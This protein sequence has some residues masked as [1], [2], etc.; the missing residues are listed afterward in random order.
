MINK[1]PA[2]YRLGLFLITSSIAIVDQF[3]ASLLGMFFYDDSLLWPVRFAL[4]LVVFALNAKGLFN[5]K[6]IDLQRIILVMAFFLTLCISFY[7]S[8]ANS[9]Q[10]IRYILSHIYYLFI[11][12]YAFWISNAENQAE[13][14]K[15]VLQIFVFF[16]MLSSLGYLLGEW[17][18][19][20]NPAGI[21][22]NII[23]FPAYAIISF[24]VLIFKRP[25]IFHLFFLFAFS[26][27][28]LAIDRSLTLALIFVYIII[29]GLDRNLIR[30]FSTQSLILIALFISLFVGWHE[31]GHSITA[32]LSTGRGLIWLSMWES[33]LSIGLKGVFFGAAGGYNEFANV[34][35]EILIGQSALNNVAMSPYQAHSVV[36]KTYWDYGILGLFIILLI[37]RN[38]FSLSV[39]SNRPAISIFVG[40]LIIA[41]LNSSTNLLKFDLLGLLLLFSVACGRSSLRTK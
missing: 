10:F 1:V 8:G 36:M 20:F 24:L 23:N 38:S 33:I 5:K 21:Y 37:Y 39:T 4:V 9:Q 30:F 34:Q 14:M 35:L 27:S 12:L 13:L 11:I 31:I 40:C 32:S 2:N 28:Y 17:D 25:L 18:H 3:I 15:F 22:L 41:S 6:R 29:N 26:I 19:Q 7:L 16:G